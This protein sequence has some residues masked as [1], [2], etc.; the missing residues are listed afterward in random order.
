MSCCV[1]EVHDEVERGRSPIVLLATD[2][3]GTIAPI[4]A[5][6]QDAVLHDGA[7]RLLARCGAIEQIAV[8]VLSG[9]DVEDVRGRLGGVRA[10]VAGSH[11]LECADAD[12][13]MLW[14]TPA[15]LPAEDAVL[16]E[17]LGHRGLLVERKKFAVAVHFRGR[18]IWGDDPILARFIDWAR[19]GGLEIL[20]GRKVVEARI[21]GEGKRAALRRIAMLTRAEHVIY[22][23]D[24]T[25]DVDALAFAAELG[26][27][28]F[29]ASS[30]RAIPDVD[31]LTVVRSVDGACLAMIQGIIEASPA[32]AVAL[33][34]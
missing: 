8:A 17:E 25:T 6:P 15:R 18:E 31:P 5:R 34:E 19:R 23:G 1:L 26:R 13:R 9:R 22:A 2:F 7:R 32:A 10:I 4:V 30:E 12:G 24:D 20:A 29:V 14:S 33:R 16:F 27:A 28:I 3:D 21:P 11:G